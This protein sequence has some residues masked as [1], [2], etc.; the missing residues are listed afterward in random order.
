[1][2]QTHFSKLWTAIGAVLLFYSLNTWLVGIGA[3]PILGVKLP[4][5]QP[6]ASAIPGI[7]VTGSLLT[8][9]CLVGLAHARTARSKS[10]HAR[11][12]VVWLDDVDTE[13]RAGLAYQWVFVFL[14]LVLPNAALVYFANELWDADFTCRTEEGPVFRFFESPPTGVNCGEY[15][16][17]DTIYEGMYKK[18]GAFDGTVTW[19][20]II[21][22]L[23]LA[24]LWLL[25]IG[26]TV[27][28]VWR[29]LR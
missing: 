2:T 16:I 3:N 6:V 9:L 5:T 12:P 23:F 25:A 20:P 28:L 4:I 8:L 27:T 14:Y 11:L 21:E 22:P 29:L 18:E 17:G 7:I 13:T 19:L 24:S 1:V 26:A 15:R 10:W